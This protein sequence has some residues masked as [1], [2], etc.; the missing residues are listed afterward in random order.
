MSEYLYASLCLLHE[1]L[2]F[3]HN[4][5]SQRLGRGFYYAQCCGYD[6]K[7]QSSWSYTKSQ[8]W[9]V[10]GVSAYWRVFGGAFLGNLFGADG[11]EMVLHL[12]VSS[13]LQLQDQ[14]LTVRHSA[15]LS[16][17]AF[18]L[19]WALSVREPPVDRKGKIDWIGSAIGTGSLILFNFVWK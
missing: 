19:L 3:R 15:C 10:C 17:A 13:T 18:F 2:C 7:Y 6:C 4:A 1:L 5:G 11:V 16:F 8:S 12:Y 14:M 9:F